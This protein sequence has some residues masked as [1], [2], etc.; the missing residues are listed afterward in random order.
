MSGADWYLGHQGRRDGPHEWSTVEK[1]ILSSQV[2]PEV[3]LWTE[4]M[5]SWRPATLISGAAVHMQSM[6][7]A[8]VPPPLPG[9]GSAVIPAAVLAPAPAPPPTAGPGSLNAKGLSRQNDSSRSS[10]AATIFLV[11]LLGGGIWFAGTHYTVSTRSGLRFYPKASFTLSDAYVNMR[12]M[13]FI[14]LRNHLGV[15]RAMTAAGDLAL[16]PGGPALLRLAQ[17]GENVSAA[18]NRFS[19]ETEVGQSL[20]RAASAGVNLAGSAASAAQRLDQRYDVTG[21][22]SKGASRALDAGAKAAD[23]LSGFLNKRR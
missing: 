13:S 18:I 21:K 7:V 16:L 5:D 6:R 1:L 12:S 9:N 19:T 3:L 2:P 14:G 22:A 23:K 4:G 10:V 17:I 15:V 20:T 11:L 8:A